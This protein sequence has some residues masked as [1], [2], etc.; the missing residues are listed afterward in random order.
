MEILLANFTLRTKLVVA[1]IAVSVLSVSVVAFLTINNMRRALTNEA[2]EA[3][4]AAALQTAASMDDFIR[5]NLDAIRTEAQLPALVEYLSLPAGQRAGSELEARVAET[6]QVLN[7]RNQ[8]YISSYALLDA[9]GLNLVDTNPFDIGASKADR[10]YFQIPM[11]TG[12]P[13]VSPVEFAP[14]TGQA[15]LYFASP[16]RND[17]GDI[18]GVLRLR[19]N[20]I[21]LQRLVEQNTGLTGQQSFAVLFDEHHLH[22][23]HGTEP[24]TLFRA[25]APL[26][27]ALIAELQASRRLPAVLPTNLSLDLT[28]LEGHLTNAADQPFFAAEDVATGEKV[29]QV[30]MASMETQPSW[31]VAYFQPREVF[32]APVEAQ[33]RTSLLLAVMIAGAAVVAAIGMGRFL[34][35]P[36][37]RLTVVARQVAEG[38]LNARA[39]IESRDET[40]Q[41]A[42]VFNSMTVQLG[43]LIGSLEDQVQKRTAELILALRVGQRAATIRDL[44]L[45]LP[46][47]T[48]LIRQHFD[49]YHAQVYLVDGVGKSLV[50]KAST[51][52]A[53]QKLLARRHNLPIGPGSIVGQVAAQA[54]AIVVPDTHSSDIHMSNPDLPET[55]SELAVPLNVAGRVIGVLDLQA[56]RPH[57]FTEKNL[58]VFEVLATQ[59]AISIDSAQQWTLA[60]AAHRKAEEAVRRLT[61][62]S[63]SETLTPSQRK[64]HLG[65]AY[66]LS[67]LTP[68]SPDPQTRDMAARDQDRGRGEGQASNGGKRLSTTV[69]VQNQPIG[70]LSVEAPAD[71]SW[72]EDEQALLKAVA[73]QL[74]LKIENLRLFEETQQKATREHLTRQITEA[75]RAAPDVD[76]IIETGLTELAKA[77]G[78]PRTYL[79]LSSSLG[80]ARPSDRTETP[81]RSKQDGKPDDQLQAAATRRPQL[82]ENH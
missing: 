36:I 65:F 61:R 67:T 38:D 77:L 41:L 20:A 29:N 33:T 73:E 71:Q 10:D 76:T 17:A 24:N 80:Q 26:D 6:L 70:W 59:L 53:G 25:T 8:V 60:Q 1:F 55:R 13:Y 31:L 12:Q 44:E 74:A 30:A 28:G 54:K 58:P 2:N 37:V 50:L 15:A 48:E 49:I 63:W 40:G 69:L 57:T 78:V 7:R 45:L 19:F 42:E 5:A 21:I 72:S 3:L 68:I 32:L 81:A 62:E 56:G 51:G 27:P 79:K 9:R 4:R 14:T 47:I 46:T 66:D 18:I 22:L 16:V 82:G 75:M 11:R 52:E 34:A 43:Q 35:G 23:A 64:P 39:V